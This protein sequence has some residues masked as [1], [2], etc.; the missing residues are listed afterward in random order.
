MDII[1]ILILDDYV[2]MLWQYKYY[3]Y[4][5]NI[6]KLDIIIRLKNKQIYRDN[7]C[8]SVEEYKFVCDDDYEIPVVV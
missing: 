8:V 2:L 3:Y 7:K 4:I 1:N 5:L 6:K